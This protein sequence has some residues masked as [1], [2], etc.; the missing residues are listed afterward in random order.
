MCSVNRETRLGK[1]DYWIETLRTSYIYSLNK[2][3]RKTE[4]N[5]PAGFSFPK[6]RER[7]TGCRNN[8]NFDNP[9]DIES[10]FSRICS[11]IT[12]YFKVLVIIKST[13]HKD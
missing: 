7:S 4:L 13:Y 11:Y 5:L 10:I 6:K 12:D 8:V 1:E 9:K 3:K 2:R